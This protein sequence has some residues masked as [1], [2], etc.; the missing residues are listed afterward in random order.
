[1]VLVSYGECFIIGNCQNVFKRL[2]F[3]L[4]IQMISYLYSILFGIKANL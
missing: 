4:T 3:R 1:M 2:S